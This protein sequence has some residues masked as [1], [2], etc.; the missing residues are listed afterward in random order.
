[1]YS[2]DVRLRAV[3]LYLKLGK[4]MRATIRQLGYPTKNSL[5]H[6]YQEFLE[7]GDLRTDYVRVI[8][9][10][11]VE[12]HDVAIAHYMDHGRCFS[13]TL[14]ALGYPS[15]RTLTKWVHERYPET[16]KCV[17]GKAALHC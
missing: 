11:S 8:P 17:V 4:R 14:K 1:M 12:Q 16:K 2:Y 5:R 6:W 13:Y 9:K 3:K 7:R 15:R 10:Y